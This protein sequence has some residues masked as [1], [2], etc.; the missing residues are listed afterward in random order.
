M[1]GMI[2]F[3][4]FT[5]GAVTFVSA[6]AA[7]AGDPNTL[8]AGEKRQGFVLLFD[9]K[10]LD[11]WDG[12]PR[13][14]RVDDGAIVGSSDKYSPE[15]NT[16]LVYKAPYTDFVL[17]AEVKLRNGNS[18]IQFRG[19]L[20]P[21]WVVHGYQA[22]L[23]YAGERSAWGNFYEE[24]GRGR[25]VMPVPNAGWEKA[26]NIVRSKD[27]N[28]YEIYAKGSHIR[29]TLNGVVTIETHDDK[30]SSG[31]I[32]FQLHT[33]DPMEVRFRG[34]KIKLLIQP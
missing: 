6:N 22:D 20:L 12:D 32:G 18:G 27:W 23:S 30:T 7:L 9:G 34:I 14:W 26:K 17:K 21:D 3:F 16:Y 11:G 2:T 33:G 24:K 1:H 8:A 25:G 28:Q 15:H 29:L 31:V 10:T 19:K 13:V 4:L 5:V